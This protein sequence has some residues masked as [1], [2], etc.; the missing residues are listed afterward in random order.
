[1]SLRQPL[2]VTGLSLARP[3][4]RWSLP[5]PLSARFRPIQSARDS[6]TWKSSPGAGVAACSEALNS[7]S[8]GGPPAAAAGPRGGSAGAGQTKL[9][10][11]VTVTARV[12]LP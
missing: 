5:R 11:Q 12:T 9:R 2:T 8:A 7:E 3:R 4:R 10:S 1:M 6:V